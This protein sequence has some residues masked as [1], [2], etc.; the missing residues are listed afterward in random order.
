MQAEK[1]L[2]IGN[3]IESKETET[4][5]RQQACYQPPIYPERFDNNFEGPLVTMQFCPLASIGCICLDDLRLKQVFCKENKLA[6]GFS[7]QNY[8]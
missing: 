7:R 3:K 4:S 5:Q 8:F 2:E 6:V 1:L